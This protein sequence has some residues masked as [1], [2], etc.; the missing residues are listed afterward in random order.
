MRILFSFLIV[1]FCSSMAIGQEFETFDYTE[2][3][4]T[5]SMKKY[6]LLLYI[7]GENRDQSP[8]E[9]KQIQAGHM[10]HL[11]KLA[12]EK[13]ICVAGPMDQSPEAQ[14][15]IIYSVY[16]KEEAEELSNDDPAVKSGR[17]DF[18]IMPFWA[19]KGSKLF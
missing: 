3:D 18:K 17:L 12:D 6:Y 8:D 1:L 7:E 5:Y 11:G 13:K 14:G 4:T 2:G 15:M 19:A 9:I 10:A 16:S